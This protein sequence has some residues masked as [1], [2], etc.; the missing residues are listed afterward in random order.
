MDI[1]NF[2]N[3]RD[4]IYFLNTEIHIIFDRPLLYCMYIRLRTFATFDRISAHRQIIS[5]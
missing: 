1:V 3:K 5:T 2:M 4:N